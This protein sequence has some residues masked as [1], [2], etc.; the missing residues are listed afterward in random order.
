MTNASIPALIFPAISLLCLAYTNRFLAL[1]TLARGIL[2]E[3]SVAPQP[4]WEVQ[5]INIRH[6]LHLIK[7]MQM[8]GLAA[9]LLAALSMGLMYFSVPW[10][11]GEITLALALVC[12]V[13][14]LATCVHEITLSIDAIEVEF[15]R[16]KVP[17]I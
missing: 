3:H 8:L 12:F 5:L 2:K 10:Y 15:K 6:R 14:S 4:H 13:S 11:S 17:E 16:A 9:L 7:R 1:T